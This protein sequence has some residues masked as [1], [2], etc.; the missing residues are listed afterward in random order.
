[1]CAVVH[2]FIDAVG[3]IKI[4]GITVAVEVA[5]HFDRLRGNCVGSP[6]PVGRPA[7]LPKR[8]WK[9]TRPAIDARQ[10][11]SADN[12]VG[13]RIAVACEPLAATEGQ[14]IDAV[15]NDEMARIK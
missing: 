10:L 8:E 12:C 9:S 11:P 4:L 6:F 5:M 13:Q 1:W 14:L 15:D 2:A 3:V 7:W